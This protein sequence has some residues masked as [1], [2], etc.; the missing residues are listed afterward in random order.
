MEHKNY[1]I[2]TKSAWK[3]ETEIKNRWDKQEKTSKIL[4]L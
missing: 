2:K 1:S 4:V 3:V